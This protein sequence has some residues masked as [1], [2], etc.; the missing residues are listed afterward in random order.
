MAFMTNCIHKGCYK[1]MEPY[2]DPSTDKVFCSECDKELTNITSFT[3]VQLKSL[4]QYKQ[5]KATSFV[6]KCQSCNREERPELNQNKI[7]CPKC[8]KEHTH[9]SEP[10]KIM[11]KEK[12][13]TASKDVA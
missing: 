5:K 10:F 9:L 7:I 11:L 3:K 13:K 2:I 1:Q 8:K 4:K 12:L 6:V